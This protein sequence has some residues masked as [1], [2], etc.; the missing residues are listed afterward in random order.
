M[1]GFDGFATRNTSKVGEA[2]WSFLDGNQA[3]LSY[4]FD[5]ND[6]AGAF[7]GRVGTIPL[8]RPAALLL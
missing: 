6:V 7:S 2:I 4:R 5:D 1:D 8:Q 3:R